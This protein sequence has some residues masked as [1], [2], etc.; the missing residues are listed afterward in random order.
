MA[1]IYI[2]SV[3]EQ[4]IRTLQDKG[5]GVPMAPHWIVARIALARSLQLPRFPDKELS[6]PVTKERGFEIHMEQLT[7][8]NTA[9]PDAVDY[10]DA[11][12]LLL[13]NYHQEDL[14]SNRPRFIELLQRHI[15]RGMGEIKA[16]WREGNDFHDYLFQELFFVQTCSSRNLA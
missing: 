8:E 13:S 11:F 12:K 14:F 7:G 16:S 2:P 1:K 15:Q 9:N 10:T 5:L 6:K 3:D 4:F